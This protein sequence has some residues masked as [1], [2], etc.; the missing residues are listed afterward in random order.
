MF[1]TILTIITAAVVLGKFF[2]KRANKAMESHVINDDFKEMQK[3]VIAQC[4]DVNVNKKKN[5]GL[6]IAIGVILISLYVYLSIPIVIT[7]SI[8]GV[9]IGVKMKYQPLTTCLDYYVEFGDKAHN[10]VCG[11]SPVKVFQAKT[12]MGNLY[13][14]LFFK[15]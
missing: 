1:L 13:E 14:N 7:T 5:K 12:K 6:G 10:K 8:M 11:I 3:T 2:E 4:S 15:Y 9:E